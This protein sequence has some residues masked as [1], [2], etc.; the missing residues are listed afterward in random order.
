MLPAL[1]SFEE[2]NPCYRG[3]HQLYARPP[4]QPFDLLEWIDSLCEMPLF[5]LRSSSIVSLGKHVTML[6]V[7][8]LIRAK[9]IQKPS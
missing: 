4:F 7:L 8:V 6:T 3:L 5:F 1:K 9:K 2:V